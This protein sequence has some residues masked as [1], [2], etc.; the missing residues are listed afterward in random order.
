MPHGVFLDTRETKKRHHSLS[1]E[2]TQ[3]SG[4]VLITPRT[5]R[6][7]SRVKGV[8]QNSL[9]PPTTPLVFEALFT[10]AKPQLNF[11][12]DPNKRRGITITDFSVASGSQ[13][14]HH[15]IFWYFEQFCPLDYTSQKLLSIVTWYVFM[16]VK[17]TRNRTKK[18]HI[19]M[20][21]HT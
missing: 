7:F 13:Y 5:W 17:K 14:F 19:E 15:P 8:S 1:L 3:Y 20:L 16:L 18:Q 12:L 9:L 6:P 10:W 21:R 4:H 11:G 2:W